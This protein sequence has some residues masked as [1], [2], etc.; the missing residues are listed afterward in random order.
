MC[1]FAPGET[2]PIPMLSVDVFKYERVVVLFHAEELLPA[3]TSAQLKFPVPLFV[4]Y[5]TPDACADGQE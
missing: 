4:R 1:T 2:V 5:F 3:T